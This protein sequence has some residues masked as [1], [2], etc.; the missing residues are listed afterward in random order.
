MLKDV[1]E[2]FSIAAM[3]VEGGAIVSSGIEAWYGL[4]SVFYIQSCHRGQSWLLLAPVVEQMSVS[5]RLTAI[6]LTSQHTILRKGYKEIACREY[7]ARDSTK[8]SRVVI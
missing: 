8:E 5:H 6:D 3:D 7:K 4:R 2:S 1:S